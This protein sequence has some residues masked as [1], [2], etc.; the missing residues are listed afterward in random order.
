MAQE[1]QTA[2]EAENA[3]PFPTWEQMTDLDKAV[4]LMHVWKRENDGA[5]YAIDNYPADY[6]DHPALV[7]LRDEDACDHAKTVVGSIDEVFIRVGAD[8]YERL[9]N[10][11][12][13]TEVTRRG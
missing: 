4:A 7:A 5:E 3:V 10:I 8:E 12:V 13:D 9:L 6:V 1:P 2:S 11:D